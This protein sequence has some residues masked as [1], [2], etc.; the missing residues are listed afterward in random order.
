MK[1][2]LKIGLITSLLLIPT[3][4][5]ASNSQNNSDIPL[6]FALAM[7][8][9]VSIHMSLFVLLPLSSIISPKDSI[10]VFCILFVLRAVILLFCDFYVT[11][12]VAIVDFIAVFIGAFIIVPLASAL[13]GRSVEKSY[14]SKNKHYHVD[15]S[16]N[17]VTSSSDKESIFDKG[18]CP[19]CGGAVSPNMKVC[20]YCGGKNEFY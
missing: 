13:T 2:V 15:Y 11:P 7:E 18:I 3:M 20:G 9:F 6:Y 14:E 4:V 17:T 16:D 19:Y 1:K 12:N 5:F 8:A 10:R